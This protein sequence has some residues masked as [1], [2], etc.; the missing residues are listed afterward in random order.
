VGSAVSL[1]CAMI[2]RVPSGFLDQRKRAG[3]PELKSMP[4][5]DIAPT[6]APR[7]GQSYP[8][9]SRD[10]KT[11]GQWHCHGGAIYGLKKGGVRCQRSCAF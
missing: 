6:L 5:P 11:K 10:K 3:F 7:T 8:T 2:E 4:I 1:S 9:A